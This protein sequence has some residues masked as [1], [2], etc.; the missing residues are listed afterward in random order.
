MFIP[1]HSADTL[2]DAMRWV[3]KQ[4]LEQGEPIHPTKGRARELSGVV[5]EIT[6]PLARISRTETKGKPFSCLGEL[7]WY[8]AKSRDFQF[9]R[10]YIPAYKRYADGDVVY[11]G[12]GPRLFDWNGF[13]QF[14]NVAE[15][16]KKKPHSRQGVIQLFDAQDILGA[17]KDVPCTCSLQFLVRREKLH[18]ISHMRSNDAF[19]G[20]PHDIFCFTMLQEIMARLLDVELGTYKHMVGSLHI[21]EENMAEARKFLDE[22]WQPTN[23]LMQP[24]PTG[25][26]KEAIGSL[27][28]AEREIRTNARYD[29]DSLME[30]LDAYWADLVR[31]LLIFRAY[32]DKD[33]DTISTIR[34]QMST[35]H[36]DPFIERR[37]GRLP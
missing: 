17:H 31:L 5:L 18:M 21:Y 13:D 34:E 11:G 2:D 3:T 30:G 25:D 12:Y 36:F 14:N 37:I 35:T 7:C 6:N 20:L 1:F 15:L 33:A 22:G 28:S 16:L 19:V 4:I 10:Y 23:I 9:I 29:P 26:P 24:M 8:L 32:K 27:L